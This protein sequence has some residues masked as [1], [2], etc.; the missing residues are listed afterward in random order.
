MINGTGSS[1]TMFKQCKRCQQKKPIG[2]FTKHGNKR[3]DWCVVCMR[4]NWRIKGRNRAR[5][6]RQYDE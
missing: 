6:V 2:A 1:R 3:N 4:E 5:R